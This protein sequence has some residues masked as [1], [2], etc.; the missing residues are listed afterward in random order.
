MHLRARSIVILSLLA[1]QF[2][3][4]TATLRAAEDI[5]WPRPVPCR[6]AD[7]PDKD[8]FVITLGAVDT[9]LA[10]GVYDPAAD[11]VRLKD[12]TVI[13]HY[14]RDRLGVKYYT[15]FDKSRFPIPPSGWCS[16][17]YYYKNINEGEVLLNAR[18]IA[19]NLKDYGA[20]LVQIDDGWQGYGK[21]GSRDWTTISDNFP[22]GMAGL[23][24]GIR[25]FG[26]TPG[27]WI[28]PHGQ[29][30]EAV[31]KANKG[32]FL[33]NKDGS[34]A[35]K[36]W[37]GDF[38]VDGSNPKSLPYMK[39]LF[40]TLVGWG[41]D[42]FKIDGQPIV[43]DEYRTKQAF[44]KKKGQDPELLYRKTLDSVRAALGP[45][46][47]LLG[48]WGI[49]VEGVGIMN[50]S[51][52]GGDV[53]LGWDGFLGAVGATMEYYYQHNIVWYA[54][55]DVM[56]LRPPLSIEQAR[57][58]ATLQG[59]TGQALFSSDRLPDLPE[60]RVEM[61]KRVFPAV[62]ARPLDLYPSPREKRIWDLKINHLGRNYDVVGVFN[63]DEKAADKVLLQW[64]ALGLPETGRVHAFDFWNKE[65]LG[66]WEAGMA[67][68]VPP[69]ACRVLMLLPATGDI[70][71]VST[72]R[73]I[74]QGWVDLASLSAANGGTRQA[75]KSHVIKGD[76]YELRFAFPQGRNF[77]VAKASARG[78]SGE[79]PV[80]VF[81]Y[82]GWAV[83]RM[84]SPKTEDIE[85]E[86]SFEPATA[87]KFDVREPGDL[88]I[89]RAGLDGV[90]L[91]WSS[92]Y[93]L[94]VGYQVTLD[95]KLVGHTPNASF[96]LRGLDPEA[97]HKVEVRTAWDDGTVSPKA[98][99]ATFILRTLYPEEIP[100]SELIPAKTAAGSEIMPA[101]RVLAQP[102][103]AVGGRRAED[104]VGLRAGTEVE[105]DLR[106]I[107]DTFSA[108]V[109]IDDAGSEM[110]ETDGLEFSVIG[111]GKVLWSSGLLKKS[112]G[113]KTAEVAVAN[114]RS[115]VLK[116][117]GSGEPGRRRR[118]QGDWLEAKLG[119]KQGA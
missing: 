55:P 99:E 33:L 4:G 87:Y 119:R 37:E 109:G 101:E 13:P 71:L 9:A 36:T 66:A 5:L 106:G 42:Y 62:D 2:L 67:V 61:L 82:Q 69:A 27:I 92:Q 118:P 85:W 115:L 58:W 39:S 49:P 91:T 14:Y 24:A 95:G 30:S 89:R 43:V 40:D 102:P 60:D 100:L 22:S 32:I 41:Y 34:S 114:V 94:N 112:D 53:V 54:D 90:D 6:I 51:R 93:Y 45:D 11:E 21:G 19:E 26:L 25:S 77:K 28:A 8:L 50:G 48:C 63:Y 56:L 110:K 116:V 59:L 76:P 73:H 44:M 20:T 98:A 108:R 74:T 70:Q 72:S 7:G 81:N 31:V 97:S 86:V 12:G 38:L 16:W 105:Y 35:S 104:G 17:Y 79:L 52:T 75:G 1:L 47:Y 64:K 23:A 18:W 57:A 78:A 103:F 15:P 117:T 113:L 80:N 111:D 3:V 84:L 88:R 65:Y 96:P 10:S 83:V 29:S 46:R 107:F 68:D